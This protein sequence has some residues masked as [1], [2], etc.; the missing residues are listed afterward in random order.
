MG[1]N[2]ARAL[3]LEGYYSINTVEGVLENGKFETTLNTVWQ[4]S[5]KFGREGI[6]KGSFAARKL[7]GETT[8]AEE[9]EEKLKNEE[10]LKV[11]NQKLID[12][13][14]KDGKFPH[15]DKLTVPQGYVLTSQERGEI[16]IA[17]R[18]RL[19]ERKRTYTASY[20]V[21][22]HEPLV[23]A[24]L[25]A[26]LNAHKWGSKDIV[27]DPT[28][29]DIT[30]AGYTKEQQK[31]FNEKYKVHYKALQKKHPNK[32]EE[33]D[34]LDQKAAEAAFSEMGT[35]APEIP[36]PSTPPAESKAPEEKNVVSL[37]SEK[38]KGASPAPIGAAGELV[39]IVVNAKYK[40][41]HDNWRPAPLSALPS[42]APLTEDEL[43][44]INAALTNAAIAGSETPTP[45]VQKML[46]AGELTS[47]KTKE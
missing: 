44:G 14:A 38:A 42:H 11:T 13:M 37:A 28:P 5:S 34:W 30:Q 33:H 32:Q 41:T 6:T 36:E 27:T 22:T 39:R 7:K 47:E 35:D 12:Q 8:F 20:L 10:A 24:E 16:E 26:D 23:M 43:E 2:L 9:R 25:Q 4:N 1:A 31:D 46:E 45:D 3:N 21:A 40:W 29:P 19:Q 18:D 17:Y 15:A